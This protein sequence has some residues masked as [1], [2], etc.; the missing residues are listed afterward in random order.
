[1]RKVTT[2]I[3]AALLLFPYFVYAQASERKPGPDKS[4]LMKAQPAATAQLAPFTGPKK[5]IAVMKFDAV[6]A[7]VAQ[8]GGSDIGGGLTAE[9]ITALNQT[10]RF[11]VL[12]RADLPNVLREQELG[13]AKIATAETAAQP[14]QLLGAQVLIRGSVT[15]FEQTTSGK[16]NQVGLSFAG[17]TLGLGHS[18]ANGH[19]AIDLRLI[20]ATTGQILDSR[21]AEAKVSQRSNGAT[22]GVGAVTFGNNAF[23]QTAL[24]HAS[25]DAIAQAVHDI[26]DRMEALPWSASVVD[27]ADGRVYLNAGRDVNLAPGQRLTISSVAKQLIDPATGLPLGAVE[28]RL[29]DIVVE[30]VQDKYSVARMLMQMQPARGD[31]VRLPGAPPSGVTFAAPAQAGASERPSIDALRETAQEFSTLS[32]S[33][34]GALPMGPMPG[35]IASNPFSAVPTMG[36]PGAPGTLPAPGSS[37]PSPQIAPTFAQPVTR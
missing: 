3:T 6:G 16:S 9:L 17:A 18:S 35:S 30:S 31:I 15:D 2:T 37:V 32:T 34:P 1:M 25:R 28:R 4:D 21:K 10:G 19:V 33:M 5:R 23:E 8:V 27:V 26:V 14:G 7:F 20:D 12:E 29:G 24:G 22:V 13:M 11:I 36:V